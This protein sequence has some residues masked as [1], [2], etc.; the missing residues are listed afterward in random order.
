MHYS[1]LIV[2]YFERHDDN[3]KITTMP[4]FNNIMTASLALKMCIIY[5]KVVLVLR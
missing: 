4:N 1:H 5:R 2:K 3:L